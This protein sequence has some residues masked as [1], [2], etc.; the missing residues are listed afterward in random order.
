MA[1]LEYAAGTERSAATGW[2]QPSGAN[3]QVG[4]QPQCRFESGPMNGVLVP[5]ALVAP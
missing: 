4:A 2:N 5:P 1:E 3:P